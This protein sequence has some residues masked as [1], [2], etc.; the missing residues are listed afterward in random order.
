MLRCGSVQLDAHERYQKM[1]FRN[2]YYLAG[3]QG[4]QLLS[5][6]LKKGRN[7]RTPAASVLADAQAN[8]QIRHWRTI[9]SFY[10][11]A[12]FFEYYADELVPLFEHDGQELSLFDWSFSSIERIAK[13]IGVHLELYRSTEVQNKSPNEVFD[14]RHSFPE[15]QD[16]QLPEIKYHQVFQ[17]RSGFIPNC[18][19]LDLLFCKGNQTAEILQSGFLVELD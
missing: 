17:D 3:P 2:R 19:I 18:S 10:G 8:W 14:I 6:P 11:R 4:Q 7:Q 12:P 1:S 15:I 5:V 13:L 9:Q 16:F